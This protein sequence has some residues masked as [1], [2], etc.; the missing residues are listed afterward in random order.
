MKPFDIRNPYVVTTLKI[1]DFDDIKEHDH[2]TTMSGL[3]GTCAYMAPEVLRY[4]QFSKTSDLW[5]C[6][7]SFQNIICI[8]IWSI[9]LQRYFYN[10]FNVKWSLLLNPELYLLEN[11]GRNS[12]IERNRRQEVVGKWVE[13]SDL[14]LHSEMR[15]LTVRCDMFNELTNYSLPT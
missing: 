9:L 14:K 3:V 6:V 4:Q 10:A 12:V 2:T 7:K 13:K 15:S 11:Y 1:A 5:R 8:A